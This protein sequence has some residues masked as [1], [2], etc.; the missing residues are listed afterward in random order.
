M[1][2]GAS[3]STFSRITWWPMFLHHAQPLSLII[4]HA[5]F[6]DRLP[7]TASDSSLAAFGS[8]FRVLF[9]GFRLCVVFC[10]WPRHAACVAV[11]QSHE[12]GFTVRSNKTVQATPMNAAVLSLSLRVR[13]CHRYRILTFS[14]GAPVETL[15]RCAFL[16]KG[17]I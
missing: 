7:S 15:K 12:R 17:T 13:L 16:K 1:R 4:E 9:I 14:L 2:Y 8:R 6:L 10:H 5:S 11:F 3:L